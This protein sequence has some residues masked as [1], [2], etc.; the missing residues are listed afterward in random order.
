MKAP[1]TMLSTGRVSSTLR[2]ILALTLLLAPRVTLAQTSSGTIAGRVVDTQGN[3]IPG[4]AVTLTKSDTRETRTFTSDESGEFVFAS[5]QPG[6]YDIAVDLQGF[7]RV[8]KKGLALSASGR[9]SAGEFRLEVG[10]ISESV[11][12]RATVSPLQAISGERS[13]VL[14]SNQVMNLMSRGRDVMALLTILPG[15]VDDDEGADALGVFNS[16]AAISGTRGIYNGMNVDGISGNVRS[17]DHIDNPVNMDAVAE[18]KVLMNSYQAEYGKGAG[19]IIN[20]VSKGGT[21]T[22]HG[23]AYDYVRNEHFNANSFFRNRQQLPRGKYRYNTFGSNLGGPIFVPGRFNTGKEK[24]FFF[25]SQEWLRNVQPNGPR[26]YTVPTVLERLGNFSQSVDV[27]S[28]RPIVIR[29]PATGQP[30]PGNIIPGGRIDPNMQRLL[31]VFPMPNVTPDA[32]HHYNLQ[33]AD[34]LERPVRQELLRVDYNVSSKLRAWVRG[35]HQSVHNKGLAST[36][37]NFTWGIGPMD[38]HTGGP[39]VGGNVTWIVNP[40]L[41]NE[42]TFGYSTWDESQIIDPGVVA[43]L[44]KANLGVTLGQLYPANNPLGVIPAMSFGGITSAANASYNSRFPLYDQAN[45]WSGSYS[46]SK[47]WRLHQFKAGIQAERAVYYQFHTGSANF[48]GSFNFG[49]TTTNPGDTGNAYANALLGNFQTYTEATSR[50][51]YAPLTRILEWYGQDSW[52]VTP[53]LTLDLGV[54]FTAG[55]PQLPIGHDASSFVPSLYD[56]A[57]AP[58]LFRPGFDARGNRVAIDPTCPTCPPQPAQLIGFLVP[59]T[60]DPNNGMV[61]SGTPG[62]PDGLVD[63]QGILAAPRFGF[64]WNP[65]ANQQTVVRGG[66]G[67]NF[68][69]RNGPGILGDATGNPPQILNPQQFNGNTATYLQVGGFQSVSNINQSLNRT[70]PPVRVYNTS[71]GIQ[72]QLGFNTMVDVAYVGSFGRHIGQKHN[73]NQVPYGA[74][75][76]PQNQDPTRPDTPL[77]DNFFRPYPGWGSINFLSFDGTSRY[78]SLQTHVVHRFSHG[79]E[80][81]GSYTLSK[82]L[83]YTN[84]DQGTVAANNS[85]D[86]WN[87]GLASYDRTHT[88]TVHYSVSLP[89]ASHVVRSA[90]IKAIFDDW[91]FNGTMKVYSG[92]PLR[93]GQTTGAG[94][95][96]QVLDNANLT[97]SVDLT[98]GGDG[99]R[100][101]LVGDPTLP[102]S[103]RTFDHWFNTA[104]FGRPAPGDRGNAGPVV[105]RGPGINNWNMSLFKNVRTG[106]RTN[107]Q[108]RAEA[109]NVFNHTQ[110]SAVNTDPR[111]DAQGNQVNL[112]FGQVTAARDPR[113]MQFALRVGF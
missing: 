108:F 42:F 76:L 9:L 53:S 112:A 3:A 71:I 7:K 44:Q 31:N 105:V 30:F 18:V 29:D 55:L 36:T 75:F 56:P 6:V 15:V 113:I 46:I 95:P 28:L 59:G 69:P 34:A 14:D 25:V 88:A 60:G 70:N 54:R 52:R 4:A 72:R 90:L 80:F 35:W 45:T 65:G 83:A 5:I 104:A 33:L 20:I 110:F 61:K 96:N 48:A 43:Q 21:R 58:A 99:W 8:E 84:G 41:V 107:V 32:D 106:R 93:W 91:Q 74:R 86:V 40:T 19:A 98:G 92:A 73:I 66:F 68:N 89:R 57:K 67:E 94:D 47:L 22:F 2:L 63:Y 102:A 101:T 24:L 62:Y 81:G 39:S 87:Y 23:A 37:N 1:R 79:M 77:P 11:E 100:P 26:N 85:R 111:F 50:A 16:P 109:Y 49:T 17:G 82:A 27:S 10:S 97:P 78:N 103:Q 51:T 13:A 64:A 12:V 38:Y